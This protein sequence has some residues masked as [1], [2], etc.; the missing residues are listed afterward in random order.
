MIFVFLFFTSLN[1]IISSCIY[2]AANG[3][4]LFLFM[5]E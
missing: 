4:I 2:V 3:I 5:T 1:V